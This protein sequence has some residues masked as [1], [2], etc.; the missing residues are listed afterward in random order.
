MRLASQAEAKAR[1]STTRILTSVDDEGTFQDH[2]C[3]VCGETIARGTP[4]RSRQWHLEYAHPA[5]G[6]LRAD[7]LEV[8]E[9]RRPGTVF[10]YYEWQCPACKLDACTVRKP[11]DEDDR[12]CTRCRPLPP[13]E[14]GAKVETIAAQQFQVGR[15]KRPRRVYVPTYTRG[16]LVKVSGEVGLVKWEGKLGECWTRLLVLHTV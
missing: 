16:E 9:R 14:V 3:R 8:H 1:F 7:E 11:R 4:I 13:L 2:P 15:G 10:S 5:C 12:R 6:W